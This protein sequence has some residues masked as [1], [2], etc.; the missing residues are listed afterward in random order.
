MNFLAHIHLSGSNSEIRTGNLIADFYKGSS[1]KILPKNIQKGIVLHRKI[2]SC[3]DSHPVTHELKKCIR[4]V[5][6]RYSG[7]AVDMFYDHFLALKWANYSELSLSV[8]CESVYRDLK[9]NL[10]Q[11]NFN[12]QSLINKLIEYRWIESYGDLIK[13]R[14]ILKQ[15]AQ[16]FN[17]EPLN[18]VTQSFE[19]N[20]KLF[21]DGFSNIYSDL[22]SLCN[23]ELTLDE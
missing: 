15:M 9:A 19:K 11:V 2:D 3:T 7:I 12:S 5:T 14:K 17:I 4:E 6:G 8:Y 20:Y 21:S 18:N 16:R 1:Y 22:L 10:E 23:Y 13:L